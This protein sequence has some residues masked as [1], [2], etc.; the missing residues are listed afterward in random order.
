MVLLQ[1]AL[2]ATLNL[3]PKPMERISGLLGVEGAHDGVPVS[4]GACIAA[5]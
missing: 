2:N 3:G 4:V 1:Q 5:V